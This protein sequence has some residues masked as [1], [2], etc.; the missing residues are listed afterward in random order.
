MSGSLRRLVHII[1]GINDWSGKIVMW[2]LVPMSL[3]VFGEVISRYFFNAPTSW[4][5]ELSAF[6][7]VFLNFIGVVY[8]MRWDGHIR[9]D[10][11]RG[12]LSSHGRAILDICTSVFIFVFCILMLWKGWEFAWNATLALERSG[13]V[14][15]PPYWPV[16]WVLPVCAILLLLQA[17]AKLIGDLFCAITKRSLL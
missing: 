10:I 5:H 14:W 9:M 6:L 13:T 16:T 7:F 4:G 12:R 1:N 3:I 17:L 2:L 11:L 15:N 8:V